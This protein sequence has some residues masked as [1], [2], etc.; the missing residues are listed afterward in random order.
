L[1]DDVTDY[2][3][4]EIER[5]KRAGSL[6]QKVMESVKEKPEEVAGVY[7]IARGF[8]KISGVMPSFSMAKQ[9][10]SD[11]EREIIREHNA[12][13]LV[14]TPKLSLWLRNPDFAGLAKD[15]L[16][17]LSN[18]EG[19]GRS[20]ANL[21][22]VAASRVGQ[23]Y[24]Q[25]QFENHALM[26]ERYRAL[27][28]QF[29][30]NWGWTGLAGDE[31]DEDDEGGFDEATLAQLE[32]GAAYWAEKL[33]YF[34]KARERNPK[35]ESARGFED[36][37][38]ADEGEGFLATLASWGTAAL[39]D[40]LGAAAWA[41]ETAGESAINIAAAGAATA[42][43]R[44]PYVGAG[45]MGA[46]SYITERGVDPASFYQ[47]KEFDLSKPE[48]IARLIS[49]P[50]ML[51]EA[52]KRGQIRGAVI[53]AMDA[54]S[55]GV[56]G[57]AIGGG[58]RP[59]VNMLAQGITQAVM[60]ST[61]EYLARIAAGQKIDWNDV[62]A[63]GFAEMAT[64]PVDILAAG[65]KLRKQRMDAEQAQEARDILQKLGQ[66]AGKS[67]LKQRA[68]DQFEAFVKHALGDNDKSSLYVDAGVLNEYF[69][70]AGLDGSQV[71]QAID[72][73][74]LQDFEQAL[75]SGGLLEIPTASYAAHIAGS[76]LESFFVE[77][78]R[79]DPQ[80]MSAAQAQ[81]ANERI[82]EAMWE[83]WSE[84]K[85]MREEE[86]ASRSFEQQIYDEMVS[87]LRVAG[88]TQEVA[89]NEAMIY[90]AFYR[91]MAE[92]SGRTIEEMMRAYPLPE[93]R[94]AVRDEG[95]GQRFVDNLTRLLA[96]A[97]V[98]PQ[99][100]KADK[101]Q[102]LL[103]FIDAYGGINDVGGE[104]KARDAVEVKR[105]RGKKT[106]RLA[107]GEES[108]P[109][110]KSHG[111]DEIA[112]A[113]VEA[114]YLHDDPAVMAYLEAQRT[115][116][117]EGDI[118]NALWAA[119]DAEL[120]GH[121]QYTQEDAQIETRD[122]VAALEEYLSTIGVSLEDSEA[123]IR[124]AIEKDQQDKDFTREYGQAGRDSG[125][126]QA[127]VQ[128]NGDVVLQS[129]VL[130]DL[131]PI[132]SHAQ[133]REAVTLGQTQNQTG[134]IVEVTK[135][136]VRKWFSKNANELK[137]N[138]APHLVEAFKQ[139]VTYH[140]QDGFDYAAGLINLDGKDI[141]VRFAIHKSKTSPKR[142]Y[143]IEGVEVTP[144]SVAPDALQRARGSTREF[145][146]AQIVEAF[147]NLPEKTYPLFQH[148][149]GSI[150]VGG[151][152]GAVINLFERADLSTLL[153]E[154]GHHFL[155]IMQDMAAKGEASSI[156]EMAV[157]KAWW[158]ENAAAVAADG[159]GAI[160][161]EGITGEA[162]VS[163]Q[164][165]A[166][167]LDE[168]TTGNADKDRAIDIGLQ[169]QFARGFEAYLMEGKAPSEG[170]RAAFEKFRAWLIAIYKKLAGLN[171]KISDEVRAAFDRMLATDE[172]I[173]AAREAAGEA[174]DGLVMADAASL[175]L[176]QE[177]YDGLLKKRQEAQDEA[178]A[179]LLIETMKPLKREG[180]AWYKKERAKVNQ[181]V[182]REV[183]SWRHYRAFEWLANRRWLGEDKNG[184]TR[185]AP[186]E[187]GDLRLDK[188]QLVERYGEGILKT[189]PRGK[190]TLYAAEGG[191]DIDIVA[192]LFGFK[193][194]D[195]MVQAFEGMAPRE[196][197]IRQETDRIMRERHGDVLR[198]GE[199]EAQALEV[200]HN[201]RRG[202]WLAGELKAIV[203]VARMERK[204]LSLKAARD[205]AAR[206]IAGMK[207]ANAAKPP[208][209]LA[210][211]RKAGQE[212]AKLGAILARQSLWQQRAR[213]LLAKKAR[214]AAA[215]QGTIEALPRQ[216]E[217]TNLSIERY[218][219]T[220]A[221]FVAAKRRQLLNHALYQE[222]LKVKNELDAALR[223]VRR[224]GKAIAQVRSGRKRLGKT[225]LAGD[226]IEPIE[227]ILHSYEFRQMTNK[228][229]DRRAALAAF[230]AKME[231][232]GRA[233]ELAIPEDVLKDAN[234]VHYQNLSV[235][236]LR[237]VV[238]ALKNIEHMARL[239]GKL[240]MGKRAR[241][242]TKVRD[243]ILDALKKNV[244]QKDIDWV[245]NQS[246]MSGAKHFARTYIASLESATTILRRLDGRQDMG[247]VYETLKGD[248]DRAA[249][250]ERKARHK[251]GLDIAKLYDDAYSAQEQRQMGVMRTYSELGGRSFS[252]W[253]VIAM[254]LNMGNEGN[255]ARLTNKRASQHLTDGQVEAVKR[256][257]SKRDW[258]FVQSV[259][260][261]IDSYKEQIAARDKRVRG[262]EPK[263]VEAKP[264]VTPYGTYR[265][266]Y[267]PIKY[268]G[269][270]GGSNRAIM[271]GDEDIFSSMLRGSYGGAATKDG[272]LKARM[273]NGEQSLSLDTNV[274]VNHLH[275]VIHDL[276]FSEPVV[277]TWRLLNDKEIEAA[278][279]RADMREAHQALKLWVQD[280][281]SGQ[282]A[283]DNAFSRGL[284]RL[285]SG[286]TISKLAF[287]L[288]TIALQPLGLM[289]SSVAVGKRNLARSM[290][291]Y[292]RDPKAMID[293]VLA[294]SNIM[295]ERRDTFNK[296]LMD[297][298]ER[299]NTPSPMAGRVKNVIE[300]Y[301]VPLG[302]A[303][304]TY[305]QFYFVDVPTWAAAY[306]RGLRQFGGDEAK[307]IHYADMTIGRTQG[308][309][310]WSDRSG[311]ERGTLS[312]AT[313]QKAFVT[314]LTTLGSYFFAKM[315]MMIE[316]T[317][318]A[319]AQKISVGQTMAYALDAALLLV[320]EAVVVAIVSSL[321]DGDGEDEED[322]IFTD[323]ALEGLETFMAG[324]PVARDMV[325]AVKGFQA[326]TYAAILNTGVR[327]FNQIRQGEVDRPFVKS[328]IDLVGMATRLPS[329]QTNRFIDG[330]W[331]EGEGEDVSLME[332]LFG[333]KR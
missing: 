59:I 332:Y 44:N 290:L 95:Q 48:D 37:A 64:A 26:A 100:G 310:L 198:D 219:E 7:N 118:V 182:A 148:R 220:V 119:I 333:R 132:E 277:N 324:L 15:D 53:G 320:G 233:N 154:S 188:A 286:F 87:R 287:N 293:E 240:L 244:K 63:E 19:F 32:E 330:L 153:H 29:K 93:V 24:S 86:E 152:G 133:A 243:G 311:F 194:G 161:Q 327:A 73:V 171:V 43:T 298:T 105:G 224:L 167:Y 102:S 239:K 312:G 150:L 84:I 236:H 8:E 205:F 134:D 221:K 315:N 122:E 156:A 178:K 62:M 54:L 225:S 56:A 319:L 307:S 207:V 250:G 297:A 227:A 42:L 75:E 235:E 280:V 28:K 104:L 22:I 31:D 255:L 30:Q 147:N 97:K 160:K 9:F 89:T 159:N 323:I 141:A 18:L 139:S 108:S 138:L 76:E 80:A 14:Q 181:E 265:G 35:S 306:R 123:D 322:N 284:G 6:A 195:E 175:G 281:A 114:G 33:N 183:N 248:I 82:D 162:L 106:L 299:A 231:A 169:E 202:Q 101:R 158:R 55:F 166:K 91:T 10:A 254:A 291:A 274:I 65:G 103:E 109:S 273:D 308:S 211:E 302:M 61:G 46:G 295:W 215:G 52:A 137:R 128:E 208:V 96:Q 172:E 27:R 60:G 179:R 269:R 203:E 135:N 257:L 20:L 94:S 2:H 45:V 206:Q 17:N 258:D 58:E 316:R 127:Q 180:E 68:P 282:V 71:L 259:W 170:L 151:D 242:F 77:N 300:Q 204:G 117:V 70:S 261:Y 1:A 74:S 318:G 285:R 294:K 72:G 217:A 146:V 325:G 234:K 136:A 246:V 4:F 303:G 163:G 140:R 301:A 85:Q 39:R 88:R 51:H 276:H 252:K 107:R 79:F 209:F 275:Q 25:S 314:L 196:Q 176:T 272:H 192:D 131:P 331:R 125:G 124:A 267:Y 199:V 99:R 92:R 228:Q 190:L 129:L 213:R 81:E 174:M 34:S 110:Q 5:R 191:A 262:I 126:R 229:I 292:A 214:G 112:R 251:A 130:K 120:R 168:G 67:K 41:L 193:S 90:P 66:M 264:V 266:G 212:A 69:Q 142:L 329:S 238:D 113:V 47:E 321:L 268:D 201:D 57:K 143:Q 279:T 245:K 3:A 83:T 309:G 263:W 38:H 11:F 149:R 278:F 200:V 288:R 155:N 253:N 40:P 177:E 210:A 78:A 111:V 237:G 289:Q 165:V 313:R 21:G 98:K 184:E 157:L 121:K 13:I 186:D 317:Q 305:S 247:V 49:N 230:V 116:K 223:R 328:L 216:I 173:A 218:N 50:Q 12:R 144:I 326:G 260:D 283:S 222:S 226:Y 270:L 145:S 271:E 16:E 232:E 256:I 197:A 304:I 164:D 189:L 296:D 241:D 187:M 36:A 185:Q 23:I 115:G 249:W